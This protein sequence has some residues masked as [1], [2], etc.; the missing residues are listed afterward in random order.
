MNRY[1]RWILQHRVLVLVTLGVMTSVFGTI[2]SQGIIASSIGNMLLG[3]KHAG[4]VDYKQRIREFASDEVIIVMYQDDNVLSPSSLARV[5]RVVEAISMLPEIGRI[6]SLLNAQ[7]TF[8]RD[9]TLYVT[10][11]ADEA[12]EQPENIPQVLASLKADPLCKGL[13]IAEDGRHATIIIELTPD[14]ARSA[15]IAPKLVSQILNIFEQHGFQT[16]HL[17]HVGLVSMMAETMRQI[18]FNIVRLFPVGCL[19]LFAVVFIMFHRF[20]P[21]LITLGVS[22]TGVIWTVGFAV[23]FDRYINVYVSMVPVVILIVATSD[24]IH[25][26]SAYLLELAKGLPKKEAILLSGSE[27]GTACFWTSATTFVGFV[28]MVFVPVPAVKEL[29]VVLGFGV[30]ISLLLALTLTPILFSL[31]RTPEPHTYDASWAQRLLGRALLS[32]ERNIFHRPWHVIVMFALFTLLS[33]FGIRR[34]TIDFDFVGRFNEKSPLRIDTTYYTTHFAGANFLDLFIETPESDGVFDPEVFSALE[35]LQQ[36]IKSWPEVDHVV[37]IVDVIQTIDREMRQESEAAASSGA[38]EIPAQQWTRDMLAQ[39]VLLFEMSGGK[40]VERLLD[41]DRKTVRLA[42]RLSHD[43]AIQTYLTG[44]KIRTTAAEFLGKTAMIDLSGLYY[45][46]GGFL[47]EFVAGQGKGLWFAIGTILL[48]LIVMFRS[49]KMGLWAMAPNIIPLL[50]LGGYLGFFWGKV[51][52]DVFFVA[53]VA[54]GIGVDDTIHFLSR[55]RF[56]SARTTD[57]DAALQRT[58]HFSGRAMVTT[59]IILVAGF[60]PLGFAS[61]ILVSIFG[62]LLP[63]TLIIAILADILLVP[64]LVKIRAIRFPQS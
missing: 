4:F 56:E 59:T 63:L 40:N 32:V 36:E 61:Y 2:A 38:P 5:E 44:E 24:I 46:L 37:S 18:E 30:A 17:H 27:V 16:E 14:D 31:M 11:Y 13:L 8:V 20:W 28:A 35:A 55:L 3:E 1:I 10:N 7:H 21:V 41:F 33:V 29:G 15:E 19:I 60:F 39:Y 23:L 22:L 43:A 26:C 25:Q 62:T 52:S 12:L 45:L 58:F 53:M 48:M 54:I 9:E 57:A 64:A 34:I 42:I 6:D 51:D 49:V 47:D 50:T